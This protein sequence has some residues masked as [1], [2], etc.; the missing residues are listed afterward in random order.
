MVWLEQAWFLAIEKKTQEKITQNSGGSSSLKD[1]CQKPWNL[2]KL[3]GIWQIWWY[4]ITNSECLHQIIHYLL[5]NT[6]KF[7][8]YLEVLSNITVFDRNPLMKR[9]TFRLG[10]LKCKS[11][12]NSWTQLAKKHLVIVP[13]PA[14][15]FR[16]PFLRNFSKLWRE[17][18]R[19]GGAS[20]P[21]SCAAVD[22]S[23]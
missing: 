5:S 17:G 13:T 14:L 3:P 20:A 10:Q 8:K 18:R 21:Y 19:R 23:R 15:L 16:L 22:I 6:T 7:V 4:L 2:T 1:F 12:R 11:C 9:S